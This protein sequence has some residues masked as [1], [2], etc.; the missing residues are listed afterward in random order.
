MFFLEGYDKEIALAIKY[1][2][3]FLS[4]SICK[5][6]LPE[7]SLRMKDT[8]LSSLHPQSLVHSLPSKGFLTE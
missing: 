1:S 8:L 4:P 6:I 7:N 2:S 5:D 3:L